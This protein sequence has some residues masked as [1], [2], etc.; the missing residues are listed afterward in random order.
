MAAAR[1]LKGLRRGFKWSCGHTERAATAPSGGPGCAGRR[2]W[3]AL[4]QGADGVG[5]WRALW[6]LWVAEVM[7]WRKNQR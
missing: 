4:G 6:A 7:G 3:A 1:Q 5:A 2:G